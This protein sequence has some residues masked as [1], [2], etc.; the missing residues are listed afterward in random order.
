MTPEEIRQKIEQL[1]QDIALLRD[2]VHGDEDVTVP[3]GE[4]GD[5]VDTNSLRRFMM[6]AQDGVNG[7]IARAEA[8]RDMAEKWAENPADSPI[9]PG[10][11]SAMHW[12]LKALENALNIADI[13]NA[14]PLQRGMV[15]NGGLPG[16]VYRVSDDGNSYEFQDLSNFIMTSVFD[17]MFLGH[18][19]FSGGLLPTPK[20]GF[21][22]CDGRWIEGIQQKHPKIVEFLLGE[23]APLNVTLDVWEDMSN[24]VT[25]TY[26]DG[27]TEGWDGIGGVARYVL[28]LEENRLRLPDLRGLSLAMANTLLGV[29][30]CAGD[31]MRGLTAGVGSL[32]Y[33]NPD[34]FIYGAFTLAPNVDYIV[35]T[36]HS[37]GAPGGLSFN[38]S[39][40]VPT[41]PSFAPRRLISQYTVW[42]GL[43]S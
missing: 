43:P 32:Y 1:S 42:L 16:H 12:A 37:A 27:T 41:G 29:G 5:I 8:A 21:G 6:L 34:V 7:P 10:K 38:A 31:T 24:A 4:E 15:I 25:Y 17:S 33:S 35:T 28:D 39:L 36:Q 19:V 2:F 30:D 22:V 18:Y 11:F 13:P 3:L 26:P 23:G 20:P 14:S 40:V 9:I